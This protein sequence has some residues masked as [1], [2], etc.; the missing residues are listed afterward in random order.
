LGQQLADGMTLHSK[1]SPRQAR[2]L[3]SSGQQIAGGHQVEGSPS[4]S[5]SQTPQI[6]SR[7]AT[8]S[9]PDRTSSSAHLNQGSE[10]LENATFRFSNEQLE[11]LLEKVSVS[12]G[13][14]IQQSEVATTSAMQ[15]M[16]SQMS[17]FSSKLQNLTDLQ[18]RLAEYVAKAN[19]TESLQ[20][21]HGAAASQEARIS[22][23]MDLQRWLIEGTKDV[24]VKVEEVRKQ[25]DVISADL[26]DYVEGTASKQSSELQG[27]R[28]T[29][30]KDLEVMRAELGKSRLQANSE[31]RTVLSEIARIQ[32][33]LQVEYVAVQLASPML[34]AGE[35]SVQG[36]NH[37][38]VLTFD[39]PKRVRD[40]ATETQVDV[41]NDWAQTD[42]VKF[43][44]NH[45]KKKKPPPLD[46]VKTGG[47][48]VAFSGADAL[49]KKAKD[50]SMKPPYSVFNYY[51]DIGMAQQLAKSQSFEIASLVMVCLNALW[52]SIDTDLN[53]AALIVDA[54]PVF[55]IVENTF[56]AF[57]LF[58][59][60]ARFAAFEHK[61]NCLKDGWFVFDS[62]LAFLM[63]LETW[64]V[65]AV[66]SAL[67]ISSVRGL[68]ATFTTI[69]LVRLA[70]LA[71]LSRMA[72]LLRAIPELLIIVKALKFA[73]RSVMVFLLM[74]VMIVYTFAVL[75]RQ[76]TDDLDVGKKYFPSMPQAMNT[77]LLH[78][79]FAENAAVIQDMTDD[80]MWLWPI[81]VFFVGLVSLTTMYMFVGILVDIVGL[82]ANTEKE[83]LV[84]GHLAGKLREEFQRMGHKDD[85]Q[86]NQFEFQALLLEPP[87]MKI[88]QDVG[89]DVVVLADMLELICEDV[90]KKENGIL[91]FTDV[92]ELILS[93]RGTNTA[94]VKDC[95]EQIR[96][97]KMVLKKSVDEMSSNLK[98]EFAKMKYE[99]GPPDADDD[100]D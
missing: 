80:N 3:G 62:V 23:V 100:D 69:R 86:I 30:A 11:K 53:P 20:K 72:R 27:L 83:S 73:A 91:T 95:K 96:M 9:L 29:T 59:I 71:R 16:E 6:S 93:M 88:M 17:G 98:H 26:K 12:L 81:L 60:L 61:R 43:E 18:Q 54:E 46:T 79:V 48:G 8:P 31:T 25:G 2:K 97:T 74:W 19:P 65:L 94:T 41:V 82:V 58:E 34:Q 56:C 99:L 39:T 47:Q 45:E 68:G 70:R 50:A 77:L 90:G 64:V 28:H 33:A 87:V 24:T 51:Y 49:R 84:V 10:I 32:K 15:R 44:K 75:M 52:I 4:H 7:A 55:F 89:V 13:E 92:V 5:R 37:D 1:S 22:N 14:Q 35:G 40:I 36:F 38:H 78:G 66:L 21:L 67:G 76:L 63:I 57:F 42:P 85:M